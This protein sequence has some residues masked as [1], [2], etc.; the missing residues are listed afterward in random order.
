MV[1]KGKSYARAGQLDDD[2]PQGMP[3]V[4]SSRAIGHRRDAENGNLHEE[5]LE[6]DN[7]VE[8]DRPPSFRREWTVRLLGAM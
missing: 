7:D 1:Q 2:V 4:H 3:P 8:D 6:Q 5:E